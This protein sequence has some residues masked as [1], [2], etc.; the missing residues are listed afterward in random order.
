MSEELMALCRETEQM[1]IKRKWVKPDGFAHPESLADWSSVPYIV[2][3]CEEA[4]WEYNLRMNVAMVR[5]PKGSLFHVR[6]VTLWDKSGGI[7]AAQV[8]TTLPEALLRAFHS[9]LKATSE[10][11][12]R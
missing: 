2:G 3:I 5:G 1:L 9:I 8:T 11:T 7:H 10:D 12:R 6:G 4:G